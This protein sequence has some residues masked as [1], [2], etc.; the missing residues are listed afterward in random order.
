MEL[1]LEAAHENPEH[2]E[3]R[4]LLGYVQAPKSRQWRRPFAIHQAGAG[5]TWHARFGW[6]PKSH[7]AKYEAGARYFQNRWISDEEDRRLHAEIENGWRIESANYVITTNHGLE[8]GVALAERLERFHDFWECLFIGY[9][10]KPDHLAARFAG[11]GLAPRDAQKHEVAYFR[12]RAGYNDYLRPHQPQIDITLGLYSDRQRRAYFFAGNEQQARLVYHEATHQLFYEAVP[13]AKDVGQRN[14]IWIAEGIACYF[15]S[16][17]QSAP[18]RYTLGG[19]DAGR[20][21]VAR[22]RLLVEGV[23]TPLAELVAYGLDRLK[24]DPNIAKLYTESAGLATFLMHDHLGRYR[25]A[26]T[27]YLRAVYAGHATERTLAESTGVDYPE[28]D[29]QYREFLSAP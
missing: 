28:L 2:K 26:L 20:M 11:K 3:A 18:D 15:E 21:P 14:N 16:L 8:Q 13:S 5:K 24:G 12:D 17:T 6:I 27:E 7:V 10:E 25:P 19:L 22:Q 9:L 29:R 23:Y 1:V 4:R